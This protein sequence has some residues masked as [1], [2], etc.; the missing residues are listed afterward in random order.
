MPSLH[1]HTRQPALHIRHRLHW[2]V[3]HSFELLVLAVAPR[4]DSHEGALIAALVDVVG[5]GEDLCIRMG[6]RF[7]GFEDRRKKGKN[8]WLV[9]CM[10]SWMKGERKKGGDAQWYIIRHAR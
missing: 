1:E 4:V 10:R 5:S 6:G 9:Q 2:R 3:W 8:E 7:D